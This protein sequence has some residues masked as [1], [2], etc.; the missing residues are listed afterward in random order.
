MKQ[1]GAVELLCT[2]C[3]PI[4]IVEAAVAGAAGAEDGGPVRNEAGADIT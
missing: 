1:E 3:G 2:Q 4:R